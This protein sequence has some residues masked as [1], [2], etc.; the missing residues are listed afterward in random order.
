MFRDEKGE[1]E[2]NHGSEMKKEKKKTIMVRR[3]NEGEK[4]DNHG[5]ERKKKEKK[6]T[7]ETEKN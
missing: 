4:E 1:K 6:K 2:D 7:I 5:S 3:G